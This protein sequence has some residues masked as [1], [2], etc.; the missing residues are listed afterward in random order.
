MPAASLPISADDLKTFLKQITDHTR[1]TT[2]AELLQGLNYGYDKAIKAVLSVR[3]QYF[4][5]YV[6]PFT[7]VTNQQDYDLTTFDP[8]LFRP[9]R[10]MVGGQNGSRSIR[11]RYRNLTN[12]E[13]EEREA[14]NGGTFSLFV[15]DVLE[16]SFPLATAVTDGSGSTTGFG[17]DDASGFTVG[18]VIKVPRGGAVMLPASVNARSTYVGSVTS[19]LPT[20]ITVQPPMSFAVPAGITVTAIAQRVLRIA[21]P[22]NIGVSGRLYYQYQPAKLLAFTDL[23]DPLVSEH[24]DLITFYAASLLLRS[25]NDAEAA[26]WFQ[27]A[28]QLRS[29]LMQ[30]I[31]PLSAQNTE[32]LS[33]DLF[34]T[35]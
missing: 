24:R 12:P 8:P 3:S 16:G 27:E 9:V 5:S 15:Y 7:F 26:N 17:V 23:I 1:P 4:L 32:G 19:V 22:P 10:L 28:Q 13:F 6:D 35:D 30:H 18:G 20:A 34:G 11:F 2:D 33:S 31:E 29:E 14:G 21:P 25:S